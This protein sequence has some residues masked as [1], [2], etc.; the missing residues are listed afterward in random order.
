[1][2]RRA[3]TQARASVRRK[4]L[5]P[6]TIQDPALSLSKLQRA[7]SVPAASSVFSR[8]VE[9]L[10]AFAVIRLPLHPRL[11]HL[12]L[13][14][15]TIQDATSCAGW[16]GISRKHCTKAAPAHIQKDRASYSTQSTENVRQC[17]LQDDGPGDAVSSIAELCALLEQAGLLSIVA[18]ILVWYVQHLAQTR[19]HVKAS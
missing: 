3:G 6:L 4:M 7:D 5:T 9:V 17:S 15:P 2:A 11:A 18:A 13:K 19:G 14:A 10:D 12:A 8:E 1:M 16:E